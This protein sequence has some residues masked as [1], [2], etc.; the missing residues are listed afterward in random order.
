MLHSQRLFRRFS[1]SFSLY[2]R[3]FFLVC[4]IG[5]S[6]SLINSFWP[7][8]LDKHNNIHNSEYQDE[9]S[10]QI[11]CLVFSNNNRHLKSSRAIVYS[12][13]KRCDRFYFV[14]RLQNTSIELMML[15][16]FENT[17]DVTEATISKY[18]FDAFSY[19][20]NE[21]VF[22]PYKWFLRASDDSFVIMPNVRRLVKQLDAQFIYDPV[23]YVG[24]VVRM[25]KKYGIATTGSVMLFNRE[26]LYRLVST[27]VIKDYDVDIEVERDRCLTSMVYDHEFVDCIEKCGV[28]VNGINDNLIL[29]QNLSFYKMNKR[30]KVNI[31]YKN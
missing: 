20:S 9:N 13:G 1:R 24:D 4:V 29:S 16:Y 12:W 14:T 26:A 28:K 19:I 15:E 7:F 17:T 27:N 30:L 10:P 21:V 22:L 31:K 23:A 11:F 6:L 3:I 25:Y 18:T 5:L 2:F 8:K